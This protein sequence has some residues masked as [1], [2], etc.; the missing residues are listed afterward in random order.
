MKIIINV[1]FIFALI[2]FIPKF[3]LASSNNVYISELNWAGSNISSSDEWIELNNDSDEFIDIGGWQITNIKKDTTNTY[4]EE[5]MLELS[6][7]IAPNDVFLISN[8]AKDHS[9]SKGESL[10]DVDPDL[11]SS[12]VSLS[13]TNLQIK[14]Y[15][16][17]YS[18][19]N[20]IDIAGNGDSPLAGD[21]TKK[22]SMSRILPKTDGN[23]K[24]SWYSSNYSI[25]FDSNTTDKGTPGAINKSYPEIMFVNCDNKYLEI[26]KQ[27]KIDCQINAKSFENSKI[28]V[29][30]KVNNENVPLAYENKY[31][32]L[33]EFYKISDR[34]F[35]LTFSVKDDNQLSNATTYPFRVFENS[36]KIFINEIYPNPSE[37]EEWIEIKNESDRQANLI[38]WIIDD[39]QGG[40][41]K[42]YQI[43][44]DTIIEPNSF[45]IIKE[46]ESK[47]GLNNAGDE[48]NLINPLGN[49]VDKVVYKSADKDYSY[50]KINDRTF[51]WTKYSTVAK[52]NL[53]PLSKYKNENIIIN[54]IMPNPDGS[55][56]GSEWIEI[57]N[58]GSNKVN[59]KNW[60]LDDEDR[61]SGQ[62]TISQSIILLPNEIK[63]FLSS[64]TKINLRN[65]YDSVRL[66]N[67][68]L[69][70]VDT[71]DYFLA[72]DHT[73][74]S[75]FGDEWLW[76][77]DI[78]PGKENNIVYGNLSF[79]KLEDDKNETQARLS[80]SVI[81]S[82]DISE[83]NMV[84]PG[85]SKNNLQP[86][87]PII[88]VILQ[89]KSI[90]FKPISNSILTKSSRSKFNRQNLFWSL[91]YVIMFYLAI[92][93]LW[94]SFQKSAT[95]ENLKN[96]HRLWHP[97]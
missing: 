82:T 72:S 11:I 63:V 43:N 20:L 3:T 94:L 50:T 42:P 30:A 85:S 4:K 88:N 90:L 46:N 45:L 18:T 75:R 58:A 6:G 93:L 53:L 31:W 49:N 15:D 71:L 74:Y 56:T 87:K 62:Y 41:A 91:G 12:K 70:L 76:T 84:L 89:A 21:N 54:E 97:G 19:S 24:D 10:L 78:T 40:G 1:I 14:L 5:L 51:V 96:I 44:K 2:L 47:I 28:V 68:D 59:I 13:N 36:N 67:P 92:N 32:K 17:E 95:Y 52:D 35:S 9:F 80:N 7:T 64:E 27:N 25:N 29:T 37:D 81:V 26:N 34:N 79:I 8:N 77:E 33:S 83:N 22:T 16:G 57:K 60:I 65:S 86:S 69:E 61:G 73:S 66:I 55:D 38:Y 39:I 23:M 48:V